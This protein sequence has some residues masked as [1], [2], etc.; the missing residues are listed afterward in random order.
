MKFNSNVQSSFR[1]LTMSVVRKIVGSIGVIA[2]LMATPVLAAKSKKPPKQ[3]L[4][5]PA[6]VFSWT[7][8]YAGVNAGGAC[9]NAVANRS[10]FGTT[11]GLLDPM[12]FVDF[13]HR[14]PLLGQFPRFLGGACGFAGGGQFGY[15]LQSANWVWGVEGD[16]QGTTLNPDD[17]RAFP[18]V[19][20][21]SLG[22]FGFFGANTEQAS[23]QLKWLATIRGRAGFL[24]TPMLM[25]YA[26]GGL[27][28]GQVKDTVSVTG[29]PTAFTGVTV[30]SSNDDIRVG[31]A[32]GGGAELMVFGPWSA[33]VEYLYYHLT[34]DTV[35]LNFNSLPNGAGTFI[36]YRFRNEGH[37]FRLGLNYKIGQ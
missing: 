5:R 34:D 17:N 7:G 9:T 18:A 16:I 25:I 29:I 10:T 1:D 6:P 30:A 2:L 3:P 28:F 35:L 4:P 19:N 20:I 8:Y 14:I 31:F 27:A 12:G 13:G 23:Q 36:N 32:G 22:G 37:I 15:N 26:T 21:P 24:A 11:F 33:K